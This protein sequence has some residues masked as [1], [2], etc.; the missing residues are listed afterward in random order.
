V[1]GFADGSVLTSTVVNNTLF[2]NGGIN[3]L[4]NF[5]PTPGYPAG[6]QSMVMSSDNAVVA[7]T[8]AYSAYGGLAMNGYLSVYQAG[9]T[10]SNMFTAGSGA[11]QVFNVPADN[12]GNAWFSNGTGNFGIGTSNP[13][14]KLD[15]AGQGRITTTT[16]VPTLIVSG[17]GGTNGVS[18]NLSSIRLS[19][20]GGGFWQISGPDSGFSFSIAQ[21]PSGTNG[22]YIASGQNSWTGISDSRLKTI[23]EPIANATSAFET[24]TPVYFTMNA[25]T[26]NI[27]HIGLIAQ[28]V[29]P[30]FPETVSVGWDGMYGLRY[31]EL[32]APLITAIKELSA[33]LS[34]V[35]ARLAVAGSTG[36]TGTT[37]STGPTG[38]T[39]ST[40]PTG[41]TESTG[42]TGPTGDSTA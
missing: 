23:I 9:T 10:Y 4:V 17:A 40:G 31:S 6:T 36:P 8:P 37:E 18:G 19:N 24:M 35:E 2:V 38:T 13:G 26:T 32:V 30:H 12:N 5:V 15:V 21:G 16:S 27:R 20:T 39:E 3:R 22:V 41:T 11:V 25:D 34:N 33:R 1:A 29:L 28:E 7:I 14:Y 42:P